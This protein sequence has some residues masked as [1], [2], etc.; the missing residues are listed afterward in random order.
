MFC[1]NCGA[2]INEG[3]K[4]C[5]KC[6][7]PAGNAGG[8]APGGTQGGYGGGGSVRTAKKPPYL[9]IGVVAVVAVVVIVAAVL[10]GK[11]IFGKGYEKPLKTLIK[12]VE[13]QDGE[14]ILSA[15]SEKTIDAMEEQSGMKKSELEDMM[16]E[17]FEY[18]FT[19]EDIDGDDIEIKYEV[20]KVKKLDKDDIKDIED[21]LKDYYDI[22][23]DISAA[24]ELDVVLTTYIDGD[25]E[26]E[27]DVELIVI[28]VDG[29]W[30]LDIDS[31]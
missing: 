7:T 9:A 8:A 24:R 14:M 2:Q 31:M 30:Y 18:M 21:E 5:P 25:E 28:K 6:G 15:F 22:K 12:G 4:F 29:K 19:D 11:A 27:E 23:E 1:K 17:E 16:E 26:D 13:E 10:I 3:S 20:E